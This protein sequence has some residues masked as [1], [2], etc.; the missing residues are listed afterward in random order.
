[1]GEI[2]RSGRHFAPPAVAQGVERVYCVPGE[3][4]LAV[5]DAMNNAPIEL[6][7]CRQETGAAIMAPA[8]GAAYRTAGNLFVTRGPGA[9][10]AAH[11]L[12]IAEHDFRRR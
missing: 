7:V 3:S 4:D 2:L 12:H 10:N 11:G 5:L 1:M 6:T 9:T 8:L